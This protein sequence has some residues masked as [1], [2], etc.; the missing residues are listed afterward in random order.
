MN[1]ERNH[2]KVI[3]WLIS[4]NQME[5][6]IGYIEHKVVGHEILHQKSGILEDPEHNIITFV[7]SN[8]ESQSGWLHN[9]EKFKVFFSWEGNYYD[10]IKEDIEEFDDLWNNR[11]S[12]TR[13]IPFPEAVKHDLI[14]VYK[15]GVYPIE[16]LLLEVEG[17]YE[18]NPGI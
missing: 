3:G 9:S 16:D 4:N 12:K 1:V 11:A 6:K 7:G 17:V 2:A 8:N 14:N 13:V 15:K 5:I 10:S 18:P